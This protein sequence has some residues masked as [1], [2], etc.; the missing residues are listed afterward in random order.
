MVLHTGR[1]ETEW[2]TSASK[3]DQKEKSGAT[4]ATAAAAVDAG[5]VAAAVKDSSLAT[6]ALFFG[7]RRR[8]LEVAT[9]G[10]V[11][12]WDCA[13]EA[14][15][16]EVFDIDTAVAFDVALGTTRDALFG[17]RNADT[18]CST[19]ETESARDEGVEN[20]RVADALRAA[21]ATCGADADACTSNGFSTSGADAG[22]DAGTVVE[23]KSAG[24]I[25]V[26]DAADASSNDGMR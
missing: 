17:T 10:A 3:T 18:V 22:A 19:S 12:L 11:A 20:S 21:G 5:S 9:L 8:V 1:F 16:D 13:V 26:R 4:A 25:S 7:V 2:S 24:T 14:V 23:K 15:G 6:D